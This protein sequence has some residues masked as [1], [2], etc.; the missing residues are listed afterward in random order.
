MSPSGDGRRRPAATR[1]K[2]RQSAKVPSRSKIRH[3]R[4]T[5]QSRK[6]RAR[7]RSSSCATHF[8]QRL[9]RP[10]FPSPFS[11]LDITTT[12]SGLICRRDFHPLARQL[13]FTRFFQGEE[14][15]GFSRVIQTEGKPP[16][17]A[18]RKPDWRW[19]TLI[20]NGAR[21]ATGRAG[22]GPV[23]VFGRACALLWGG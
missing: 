20:Q 23:C 14:T 8:P 17:G 10:V 1:R 13:A 5:I 4:R 16:R 21:C 3:S 9:R 18:Q 15:Y 19:P 22:R 11:L 7:Q 6:F 12:V 2:D